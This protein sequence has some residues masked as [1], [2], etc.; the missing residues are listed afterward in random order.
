MLS[1]VACAVPGIMATRVIENRRDRLATILVAPLM[2]CSARLPVYV[3]MI[4]AFLPIRSDKNPGGFAWYVPG[5]VM[6][7][8]YMI[9]LIVAPLVALLLKRTLLRGET[10]PFVME[11]PLYKMPSWRTILR[12]MVDSAWAFLYRAGTMILASMILV[13]VLLY[14]P[15][16]E[17]AKQ[18]ATYL[19]QLKTQLAAA[20]QEK[21]AALQERIEAVERDGLTFDRHFNYLRQDLDELKDGVQAETK[22]DDARHDQIEALAAER[23][24]VHGEWKRQSVL[25]WIGRTIEPV[26]SP[27]GWDWRIAMAAVASFPAREVIVGTLGIIYNEGKVKS[28]DILSADDAGDTKLAKALKNARWES[29]PREGQPVFTIPTALSLMVFF[30]LCCQCASTLTVIRRETK[31]WLWPLFTFTYMTGLAYIGA[32]V[33]YQVGSWLM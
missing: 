27:L 8:M 13:W 28:D 16:G 19:A 20:P 24:R 22:N 2:S 15:N 29:G 21:Q 23:N 7:S 11:M 14:Y 30:A 4:G 3:L 9:G 18:Q 26:V 5:L 33:V 32:L 1:S 31:S 17:S 6:F 25:G 12:R 10:P